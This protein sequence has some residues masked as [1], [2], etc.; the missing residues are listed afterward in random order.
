MLTTPSP[1]GGEMG[2]GGGAVSRPGL[3]GVVGDD[4]RPVR[5]PPRLPGPPEIAH[6]V[7]VSPAHVPLRE[8]TVTPRFAD[9]AGDQRDP[10]GHRRVLRLP[11]RRAPADVEVVVVHA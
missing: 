4:T 11:A 6:A 1:T 2:A 8:R 3:A 10:P 7:G 9:L 5:A